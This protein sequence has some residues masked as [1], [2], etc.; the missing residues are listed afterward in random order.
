MSP[1]TPHRA[2]RRRIRR[3]SATLRLAAAAAP[4]IDDAAWARLRP[5]IPVQPRTPGPG[6][7]AADD[8][9]VLEALVKMLVAHASYNQLDLIG[10]ISGV[11]VR[12]RLRAWQN[13]GAWD[14]I[15]AELAALPALAQRRLDFTV[16]DRPQPTALAHRRP[17]R[18]QP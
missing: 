2:A 17:C 13:A 9:E 7:P 10:P 6:R 4:R 18:E 12:R 3:P 1:P 16:L 5:L 8:R 14:A 11:T 15:S